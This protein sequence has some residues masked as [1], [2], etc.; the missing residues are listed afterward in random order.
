[1][2]N[3]FSLLKNRSLTKDQEKQFHELLETYSHSRQ[4]QWI[5]EIPFHQFEI[6]WCDAM[7]AER[8]IMGAYVPWLGRKVFLM[9]NEQPLITGMPDTWP[10]VIASTLVHELRHAWQYQKNKILYVICCLPG[11]R[12]LTLE[13]DARNVTKHARI[14][15]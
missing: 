7:T 14:F 6:K 3:T 5:G 2:F 11:I 1:M 8:G 9:P 4:G 15:F 13:K 10:E 12:Q